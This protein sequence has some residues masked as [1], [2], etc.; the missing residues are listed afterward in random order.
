MMSSQSVNPLVM[1]VCVKDRLGI[2]YGENSWEKETYLHYM[3][4][5][6][7]SASFFLSS[8]FFF[9]FFSFFF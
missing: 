7:G 4:Y 6:D 1:C 3:E 2:E 5:G 8:F 9:F